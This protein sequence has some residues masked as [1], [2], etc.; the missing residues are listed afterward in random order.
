MLRAKYAATLTEYNSRSVPT[1]EYKRGLYSRREWYAGD[2]SLRARQGLSWP[3][4]TGF[5]VGGGQS[6]G[7]TAVS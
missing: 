4:D 3:Y 2:R 1:S 6:R 7:Q 5:S